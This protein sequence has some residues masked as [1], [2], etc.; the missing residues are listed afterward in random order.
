MESVSEF[1]PE[2]TKEKKA[3]GSGGTEQRP[4]A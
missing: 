2:A 1:S 3:E 4:D